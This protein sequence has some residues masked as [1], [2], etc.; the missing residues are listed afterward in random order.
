M[1][2]GLHA[3]PVKNGHVAVELVPEV[4]S[5]APGSRMTIALKVMMDADWHTYWK[6]PGLGKETKIKWTLPE[7]VS[8]DEIQWP[9]PHKY[10]TDGLVN[11]GYSDEVWL[12][13]DINVP[14]DFKG[15]SVKLDAKVSW[16]MCKDSCIPGNAD[17]SVNIPVAK[18]TQVNDALVA[19][20]KKA[21]AKFPNSNLPWKAMAK[22][23]NDKKTIVM[24]LIPPADFSGELKDVYFFSGQKKI[25]DPDATQEL[26]KVGKQYQLILSRLVKGSGAVKKE[27]LNNQLQGVLKGKGFGDD[28][29]YSVNIEV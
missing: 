18:T 2:M 24:T 22:E 25:V 11:Y 23:S 13:T 26:K 1:G 6:N 7:G 21:R 3:E 10:S 9:T 17:V 28:K 8:A 29:A 5:V 12:L 20:F 19:S 4:S 16:L 27:I 15:N 14:K